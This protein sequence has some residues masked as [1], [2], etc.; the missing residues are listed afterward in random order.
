MKVTKL[1]LGVALMKSILWGYPT[2][3]AQKNCLLDSTFSKI[4]YQNLPDK[5]LLTK[6]V[7]G[8]K[9]ESVEKIYTDLR[10]LSTNIDESYIN[11]F[12]QL[13]NIT[14]SNPQESPTI[15]LEGAMSNIVGVKTISL[16]VAIWLYQVIFIDEG[17]F[18]NLLNEGKADA[19]QRN[20]DD[21]LRSMIP[22]TPPEQNDTSGTVFEQN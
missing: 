15:S 21:C 11:F 6:L 13:Q 16:P 8:D 5:D 19:I 3:D 22:Q 1:I 4:N 17:A 18:Q 2:W 9:N 20:F 12:N 14:L 7:K 10:N